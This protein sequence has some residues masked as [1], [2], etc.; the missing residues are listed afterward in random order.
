MKKN[1]NEILGNYKKEM[2]DFNLFFD[3]FIKSDIKTLHKA[4]K[5]ISKKNGKRLRPILMLLSFLACN[6]KVSEK[7]YKIMSSIELLH[8]ASLIHDD[9][10]DKSEKRRG[11]TTLHKI[12]NNKIA[13]LTGDYLLSQS[14]ILLKE[15][16]NTKLNFLSNVFKKMCEGEIFQIEKS[17]DLDITEE[18]YFNLIDR[19]ASYLISAS[20]KIGGVLANTTEENILR[21]ER[22]GLLLGRA[23][24][25]QDDLL[26]YSGDTNIL[27]KPI[28]KD[29][30]EK[31][32]TL[33]LIYT[34]KKIKNSEIKQIKKQIKKG[35]TTKQKKDIIKITKESGGY[36]K[37]QKKAQELIKQACEQVKKLPK[38][39]HQKKLIEI[40]NFII[41]REK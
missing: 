38:T 22:F 27:G 23:F 41:N 3:N 31:K 21:L 16:D 30:D 19:K 13:I 18:E 4:L 10:I 17:N 32:I 34:F 29:L 25:I 37:A 11:I 2:K 20:C 28:M 36:K 26:D 6:G 15:I 9:V 33:P 8:I 40:A 39:S 14:L 1:L 35:L 7:T 5:H 12:W 24:Q